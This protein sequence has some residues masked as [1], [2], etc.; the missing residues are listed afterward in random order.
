[1]PLVNVG[2]DSEIEYL[3]DGLTESLINNLSQLPELK[4]IP[5]NSVFRYKGKDVDPQAAAR[6]LNVPA[7][8]FGRLEQRGDNLA[9][10]LELVDL[11][12]NRQLW[13]ERYV[14]PV[15]EILQVQKDISEKVF[16][17][18][19]LR[20]KGE[21]KDR[22]AKQPT[23]NPEAYQLYLRGRYHSTVAENTG[24]GTELRDC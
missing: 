8:L 20:L 24:I 19:R 9:I 22:L 7:V 12:E 17:K 5:R 21:D 2:G 3:A 4:V 15:S 16:E 10:S 14:R 6:E 18:L 1:M 13:G 23:D 11:R